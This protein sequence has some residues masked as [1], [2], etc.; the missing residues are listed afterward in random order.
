MTNA[1][2]LWTQASRQV[3]ILEDHAPTITLIT[4]ASSLTNVTGAFQVE[5]TAADQDGIESPWTSTM[6]NR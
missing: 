2:G 1:V 4:P 3:T 6:V 5:A